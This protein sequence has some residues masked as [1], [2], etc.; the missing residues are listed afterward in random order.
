MELF[1]YQQQAVGNIRAT[2]KSGARA[3]LLVLP[4]GGGKT[5]VF[6]FIAK[7]AAAKGGALLLA[8]RK[9]LV[10]QISAALERWDVPHGVVAPDSA[11]T[12][13]PVQ[14]AM[15]QTLARRCKLDKAGR[16]RRPLVIIDEA[17]HATRD[18][19]WGKVLEHNEGAILL[20]VSATPCRLD[21][22][23]LGKDADGFF[24]SIIVGPSV[25][26][27]IRRGRLC[28]PVVYSP[29]RLPDLEGVKRRGG[30]YV[31]ADLAA[32][33]G[34]LGI[35][36]DAVAHYTARCPRAPAIAFCVDA[37]H[38]DHVAAQFSAAGYQAA[39]LMGTTPDG[40][41][42]RMIADL[43][44][45]A[46][47]VLVSVN[48][49]SEGTDI[50]SV[51]AAIMLRPTMSFSLAMQQAGR[52]LRICPGKDRAIILDH[53]GNMIKHGLPTEPV[54]W[55]LDGMDKPARAG[56]DLKP[57]FGCKALVA[58]RL[59]ECPHC[60]REL[61]K[62]DNPVVEALQV[63]DLY[64]AAEGELLELTPERRKALTRWREQA[65]KACKTF[66]ELEQVGKACGYKEGWAKHRWRELHP[67]QQAGRA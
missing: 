49:V 29:E 4:T 18:S 59:A 64:G 39:V 36:G 42:K 31:A 13:H 51:V 22:K 37:K 7:G 33:V 21:G 12:D 24:D 14:V 55:T 17:H 43:G 20:G 2:L 53:A 40:L 52:A 15:V 9:E 8:H 47:H 16:Y 11:P 67:Q 19:T 50:P 6:T 65:E 35:T 3:P 26:E 32:R 28:P 34:A 54:T 10:S 5:V 41:R 44:T 60:G 58:V 1:D 57:C 30:D 62:V 45:G 25:S 56:S 23:G 61:R 46:L 63:E 66:E 48:V 38:A 27:L